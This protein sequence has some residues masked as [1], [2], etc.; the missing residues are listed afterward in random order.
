MQT[1]WCVFFLSAAGSLA[2]AQAIV[3]VPEDQPTL[4]AGIDAVF[5]G[6]TVLV[7]PGTYFEHGLDFGGKNLTLR[8]TGGAAATVIDA[9]GGGRVFRF[10]SGEARD[11]RVEGF[12]VTGGRA[13]DGDAGFVLFEPP[14]S[15]VLPT[16]GADGGGVQISG[17]SPTLLDCVFVD[18]HAGRGGDGD[19]L[20]LGLMAGAA[21]GSGGA[22]SI[23]GGDPWIE[24]CVFTGNRAGDGGL[25]SFQASAGLP[26]FDGGPGGHG[27]ALFKASGSS[28]S[29]VGCVFFDNASGVGGA[30][31]PGGQEDLLSGAPPASGGAGGPGGD[32]GAVFLAG[33]SL[34][35]RNLSVASNAASAGGPG[36][37]GGLGITVGD[38]APGADGAAGSGGGLARQS[39]AGTLLNAVVFA[40]A[41][42]SL[43]GTFGVSFSNLAGGAAGPGNLDLDPAFA[44]LASG[45]LRLTP[46]SPCVDAGSSETLAVT[47]LDADASSFSVATGGVVGFDLGTQLL[48]VD[49]DGNRRRFDDPATPDTGVGPGAVVDMGAFELGALAP[50]V[51]PAF[52]LLGT[53]S[54]TTPGLVVEGFALALNPDAYF[55]LTLVNP[56]GGPLAPGLGSFSSEGEG[57][58]QLFLPAGL[59]QLGGLTAHHAAVVFDLAE[60]LAEVS[61]AVALDFLP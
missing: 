31:G 28:A 36:G 7:A 35:L 42:D 50:P 57:S 38:A 22:I 54:G 21:G 24:G 44:S 51:P 59:A 9:K 29:V 49:L 30:G 55:N 37:L 20:T 45:D 25:G 17:A 26:G 32:G 12:T 6:G 11:A 14:L 8:S 53:L 60:G 58:G 39:G 23:H 56:G 4:Q 16:E 33:G 2:Q 43:A 15:L 13:P 47:A 41:P 10:L 48:D 19:Q 3:L 46:G 61:P 52:W 5:P 40:N 27:G 34:L 18:N 1:G